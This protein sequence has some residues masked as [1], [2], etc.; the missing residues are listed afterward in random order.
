MQMNFLDLWDEGF[1]IQ[2]YVD[3]MNKYQK[4]MKNRLRDVRITQSECQRLRTYLKV[5]KI[6][7]L[8]DPGCMDC[9]MN[10]PILIKMVECSPNLEFKIFDRN[11]FQEFKSYLFLLNLNR[12]P[13][14]YIMDE[15][16]SPINAWLERPKTAE[17]LIIKWKK[18]H[19]DYEVLKN[20]GLK[21]DDPKAII[22]KNLKSLYLDEMW[23]WYDTNLQSETIKEILISL[24]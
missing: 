15:D 18:E 14:F 1:D 17:K 8:S 22:F 6:F 19:P 2:Q 16:F 11:L 5:R 9:L 21:D 20:S 7:V 3:Q 23:N 12:I 4:E 24:N 10:I 13:V